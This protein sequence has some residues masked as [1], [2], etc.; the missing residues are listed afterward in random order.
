MTTTEL[1]T[2]TDF[3]AKTD[4]TMFDPAE[5]LLYYNI[6]YGLLYA[7]IIDEGEDNYEE[8]DTS[9]TVAG[10]RD[11]GAPGRIHH[12]NWLKIDYG[13]GFIPARY[14]S[15]Q[16]LISEYGNELEDALSQWDKSA[17]IYWFKGDH[18]FI[19]PAPT[20]DQAG[21]DR[22][23]ASFELLPEDLTDEA[24]PDIPENFH[25][26]LAEYAAHKY[27]QNNGE[28]DA[29]LLRKKNFDEGAVLMQ[30]TMFPR[31]RQ[32]FIQSSVPDDDGS[33]Y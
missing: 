25:Y 9:T 1:D 24:T 27:H 13:E 28:T 4:A 21:S 8:E 10:Q 3:L 7:L 26:L 6:A 20:T 29:A 14:K 19:A 22:L 17:P 11:Y 5:K 30:E 23:K 15:E 31:A 2:L 12:I 16:S 32:Q 18:F 33:D